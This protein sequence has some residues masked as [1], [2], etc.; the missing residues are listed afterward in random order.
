MSANTIDKPVS[1]R[2]RLGAEASRTGGWNEWK[3]ALVFIAPALVGF[4]VFFVYPTVRGFYFS[5]TQ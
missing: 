5:L 4:L 2:R 1:V 3:I